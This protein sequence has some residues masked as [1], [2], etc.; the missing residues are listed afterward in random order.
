MFDNMSY[1]LQAWEKI[2]HELGSPLT[3][4]ALFKQLYGKNQEVI[5]RVFGEDRFSD[6]DIRKISIRKDEYFRKIYGPHIKLIKGLLHFLTLSREQNILL[7]IGTGGLTEN[8]DFALSQTKTRDFFSAIVSE[9]D[10]KKSKPDPETFLKAAELLKVQPSQCVVFEDV[11]KGVEAA[12]RARMQ[13]V[14]ILTSHKTEDFTEYKN[15]TKT[16]TDY[17]GLSPDDFR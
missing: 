13:A 8:I 9:V 5:K 3:G 2:M 15:V 12:A 4:E 10:V 11:P 14:V 6:E 17:A 7:A 16:I 1:H